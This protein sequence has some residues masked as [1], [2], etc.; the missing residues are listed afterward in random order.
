MSAV[1]LMPH[2]EEGVSFLLDRKSGLVAFEQGLGKTRV[3]LE[4]FRRALKAGA[5]DALIVICPNSLKDNWAEEVAR[6][7]PGLTVS[8]VR[9]NGRERRKALAIVADV[10]VVNYEAAR[11]DIAALRALMQRRRCALVLDESHNVKNIRTLNSICAP[12]W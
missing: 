7:T 2:Q 12:P 5:V 9:G 8:V 10:F 6:F 3:A 1:A 4:A 11:N